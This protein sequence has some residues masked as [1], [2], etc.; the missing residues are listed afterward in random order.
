MAD[1][2][3]KQ[4]DVVNV[5]VGG[6]HFHVSR[7]VLM[8]ESNSLLDSLFSGRFHVDTQADG[9]IFL[10]RYVSVGQDSVHS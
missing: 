7:S 4:S 10:D 1:T 6:T 9:S 5:D 2:A 3:V 8:A